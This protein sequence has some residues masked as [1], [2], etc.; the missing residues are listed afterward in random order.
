MEGEHPRL[1]VNSLQ[2]CTISC[3]MC[4]QS[5][6]ITLGIWQDMQA[7]R[8]LDASPRDGGLQRPEAAAKAPFRMD[9]HAS[10]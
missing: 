1:S 3:D 7:P 8:C 5:I 10:H 4:S 6:S 9:L 2:H